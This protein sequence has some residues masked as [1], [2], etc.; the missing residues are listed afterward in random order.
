MP[1]VNRWEL[2]SEELKL[3]EK[4]YKS[5]RPVYIG[6]GGTLH[7]HNREGIYDR[8][9]SMHFSTFE[10]FIDEIRSA[11]IIADMRTIMAR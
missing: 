11:R 9:Y 1:I 4:A 6:P 5:E 7:L 10:I 3:A 2:T 8:V